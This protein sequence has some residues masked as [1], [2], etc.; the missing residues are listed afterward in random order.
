MFK[1]HKWKSPIVCVVNRDAMSRFNI[2]AGN[3]YSKF[4]FIMT[5]MCSYWLFYTFGSIYVFLQQQKLLVPGYP[6]MLNFGYPVPGIT[7]NA[8]L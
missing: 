8:Q 2:E 4:T 3:Y 5:L 7:E 1:P 6:K